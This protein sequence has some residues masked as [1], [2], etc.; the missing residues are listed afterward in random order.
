MLSII[1][2]TYNEAENIEPLAERIAETLADLEYEIIV[3]DDDSPD[4]TWERATDLDKHLKVKVVRRTKERG[5]ASAVVEGFSQAQGSLFAVIDADLSHPPE[6]LPQLIEASSEHQ[7]VIGSRLI[8][9][10]GVELWP[11]YRRLLSWCGI[12][13]ARPL[14]N[15]RDIMSGYFLL[16][17]EILASVKLEPRGYKILLEI[18]V[19]A[20]YS[21]L[22]EIPYV[23][24]CREIGT[25]KMT[26]ETHLSYLRQLVHLYN[27]KLFKIGLSGS[28]NISSTG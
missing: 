2:P 23:F 21:S 27:V 25:S 19:K 8:N 6:L 10:G 5:L 20:K 11:W 4:R 28:K 26:L 1:V 9:G 3:V 7:L 24:K 17:P 12:Q 13:L 18:L 14:T 15:V 16:Y 22:I